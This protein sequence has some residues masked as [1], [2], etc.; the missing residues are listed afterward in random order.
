M[1]ATPREAIF[2]GE[3]PVTS[4]PSSS[5][6]PP[7]GGVRPEM[8][9]SNVDLPAPLVPSTARTSPSSTSMLTSKRICVR[10]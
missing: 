6:F 4:R 3:V 9:R 1:W 5:T 10:P 7:F 2:T 8:A